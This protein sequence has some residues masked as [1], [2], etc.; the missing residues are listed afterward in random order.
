M[1]RVM[2]VFK[3]LSYQAVGATRIT[4]KEIFVGREAE[5]ENGGRKVIAAEGVEI[6]VFRL[7]DA[8]YAWR[9]HCPHQGGPVCQGRLM[10]RVEER[11]DG[12]RKSLGIHYVDG[13]LNMI[14]PW[15]GYEFDV[16]TGRHAGYGAVRLIG[17]KVTLRD[18]DIYVAVPG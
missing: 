16:R 2:D 11:L 1:A 9:N 13:S 7:D 5:I 6:G 14:C 8:F 18:G 15:H 10:K 4:V 3:R 17:Y 12:E